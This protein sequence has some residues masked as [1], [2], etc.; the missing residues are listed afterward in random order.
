MRSS[1]SGD[2]LRAAWK[3]QP[4]KSREPRYEESTGQV[5]P[6]SIRGGEGN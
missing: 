1:I 6:L 2:S 3:A 4:I 5:R